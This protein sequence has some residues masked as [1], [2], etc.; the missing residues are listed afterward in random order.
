MSQEKI[1]VYI[2]DDEAP[3]R[4][5]LRY[6]LSPFDSLLEIVGESD[7]SHDALEFL[8]KE[9]CDLLFLD[10]EMPEQTGVELVEVLQR[11]DEDSPY[12][13]FVT[14]YD[15]FALKAFELSAVDYLLK[16]VSPK[17]LEQAIQKV[18]TRIEKDLGEHELE[19]SKIR[20]MLEDMQ[21][22]QKCCLRLALNQGE[23]IIPIE[24]SQLIYATVEDKITYVYTAKGKFSYNGTLNELEETLKSSDFFR[25]HKSYLI[26]LTLI[27]S[28]EIW[29]NGSYQVKLSGAT[30][31]VPISRNQAKE[32]KELLKIK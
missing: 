8:K 24:K 9:S 6:L 28:I 4:D 27:E 5:E 10:I 14:A 30:D 26:N 25:G 31:L 16:P 22:E 13:I 21:K 17:R 1:K 15:Q 7:N 18:Q 11:H 19:T 29:F 2:V 20:I 12:V 3:A 32:F 23:K